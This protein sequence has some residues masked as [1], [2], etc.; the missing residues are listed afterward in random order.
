MSVL[1]SSLESLLNAIHNGEVDSACICAE[2]IIKQYPDRT[3][4]VNVN[5]DDL[6]SGFAID[7]PRLHRSLSRIIARTASNIDFASFQQVFGPVLKENCRKEALQSLAPMLIMELVPVCCSPED[8]VQSQVFPY[9]LMHLSNPDLSSTKDMELVLMHLVSIEKDSVL[10][11][12]RHL[13]MLTNRLDSVVYARIMSLRLSLSILSCNHVLVSVIGES[14]FNDNRGDTLLLAN[15]IEVCENSVT[16]TDNVKTLIDSKILDRVIGLV[17]EFEELRDVAIGLFIACADNNPSSVPLFTCLFNGPQTVLDSKIHPAALQLEMLIFKLDGDTMFAESVVNAAKHETGMRQLNAFT[18]INRLISDDDQLERQQAFFNEH[19]ADF[20]DFF[21]LHLPLKG[22]LM[23][24]QTMYEVLE[25]ALSK[26]WLISRAI[27]C[28]RLISFLLDRS[29]DASLQGLQTK[30]RIIKHL[31]LLA[32]L[33]VDLKSRFNAYIVDG[34]QGRRAPITN[35]AS[36][37]H[38]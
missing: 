37:Y 20:F 30:Y 33:P 13:T 18:A 7:S 27:S 8:L 22:D 16:S 17:R 23:M 25:A 2:L 32:S 21:A 3:A 12:D 26:D 4:F 15:I 31:S 38:Q 34:V 1:Q 5:I 28:N 29:M 14:L 24:R 35:V 11:I 36:Q 19:F 10:L 9:M 6:K